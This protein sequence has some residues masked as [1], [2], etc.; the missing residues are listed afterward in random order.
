VGSA[1]ASRAIFG[2]TVGVRNSAGIAAMY[3]SFSSTQLRKKSRHVT[4]LKSAK[5]PSAPKP[6]PC[7]FSPCAAPGANV[8][9]MRLT[10]RRYPS[11]VAKAANAGAPRPRRIRS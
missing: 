5:A 8:V 2:R 9:T 11:P 4:S 3:R 10:A 6:T 7:V 1:S